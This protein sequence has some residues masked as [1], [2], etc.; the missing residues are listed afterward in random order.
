MWCL[1]AEGL[2]RTPVELVT[3]S[4]EIFGGVAE[5]VTPGS[6]GSV[7]GDHDGGF[8]VALRDAGGDLVEAARVFDVYTGEQVGEGKKSLAVDVVMRAAD[9]TLSADEVLGVREA[10]IAKAERDFGAVLR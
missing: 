9:H 1:P 3:D 10:I 6:D 4:L 7:R 2:A 5:D 8:Q